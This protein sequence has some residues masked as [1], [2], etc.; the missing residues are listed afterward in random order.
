M[1]SRVFIS[2]RRDDDPSSA[3]RL[4]IGLAKRLG[5]QRVFMD[6]ANL[7]A[8]Q[9]FDDHLARELAKCDVLIAVIGPRWL[10]LLNK[11][12]VAADYVCKEIS[13]GLE[14][15]IIVIPVRVGHSGNMKSL[16]TPNDLPDSIKGLV[17]HQMHDVRY[18]HFDADIKELANAIDAVA[19]SVQASRGRRGIG[20]A[21]MAVIA[22]AIVIAVIHCAG[23][24]RL[25]R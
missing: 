23:I 16:P 6:V 12:E 9:R 8:G 10:E 21:A 22:V 11:G 20:V 1:R 15:N 18:G 5:R 13:A 7:K 24:L 19:G 2:Y 14:R 17:G 3:S 25:L 4:R